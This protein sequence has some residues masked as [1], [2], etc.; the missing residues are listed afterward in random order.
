MDYLKSWWNGSA[1]KETVTLS[2]TDKSPKTSQKQS[3]NVPSV[4]P[5]TVKSPDSSKKQEDLNKTNNSQVTAETSVKPVLVDKLSNQ[6]ADL[7][8][9]AKL[10]QFLQEKT[11]LQAEDCFVCKLLG[12]GFATVMLSTLLLLDLQFASKFNVPKTRTRIAKTAVFSLWVIYIHREWYN[13]LFEPPG[14]KPR[15]FLEY[16]R[17]RLQ[18]IWDYFH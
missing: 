8:P 3:V 6:Y 10:K 16:E 18:K 5:E 9:I 11:Y 7:K 1:K 17:R 12:T 14:K 2:E 15:S 13:C 4:L